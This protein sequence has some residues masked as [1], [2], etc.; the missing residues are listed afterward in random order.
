MEFGDLVNE[1]QKEY[2][3]ETCSIFEIN[4]ILRCSHFLSQVMHESASFK[5]REENLN[6]SAIGLAKTWRNRFAM[7]DSKGNY[8]EPLQPNNLAL[9]IQRKPEEI[10]NVVYANRMGNDVNGD[11]WKYRGRG[12]IQLT[13]KENYKKFNDWLKSVNIDVDVILE[14]DLL[15]KDK[16]C[17]LS[18]GFYWFKNNLNKISDLGSNEDIIKKITKIINGGYI[19]LPDRIEKFLMV[20]SKLKILNK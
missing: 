20:F 9:S 11:G 15:L 10:A 14:P 8:F 13:G 4:T 5:Y 1:Q 2:L 18:A 7:K 3:K 16:Y 17:F 12:Y 19:G 6:Y